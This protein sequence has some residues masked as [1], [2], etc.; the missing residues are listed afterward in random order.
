[1][2]HGVPGAPPLRDVADD[3]LARDAVEEARHLPAVAEGR[4][5]EDERRRERQL[6]L[7]GAGDLEQEVGQIV[8]ERLGDEVGAPDP[9]GRCIQPGLPVRIA[10]SEN[11][12]A[13]RDR[14][15]RPSLL[16]ERLH[17]LR[18]EAP[19]GYQR[20]D[21]Q[22]DDRENPSHGCSERT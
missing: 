19:A 4:L 6:L 15:R 2:G 16:R 5:V 8:V 21:R 17:W 1:M 7:E 10:R 12:A 13:E 22:R 20:R 14:R 18:S 11:R 9:L 3:Q